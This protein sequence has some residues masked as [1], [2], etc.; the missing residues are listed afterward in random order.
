MFDDDGDLVVFPDR[1][2]EYAQHDGYH[3][4]VLMD[5]KDP[6]AQ[7]QGQW[8]IQELFGTGPDNWTG[9]AASLGSQISGNNQQLAS[10]IWW[11]GQPGD[12]GLFHNDPLQ[13]VVFPGLSQANKPQPK[14]SILPGEVKTISDMDV[15]QGTLVYKIST[16]AGAGLWA[17]DIPGQEFMMV[18]PG[19]GEGL[20]FCCPST[21]TPQQ[22]APNTQSKPRDL[23]LYAKQ[24]GNVVA[25]TGVSL[26]QLKGGQSM[27]GFRDANG[28]GIT[29]YA[30]KGGSSLT[31]QCNGSNGDTSGPS[32]FMDS[33]NNLIIF[34]A[35][36]AQGVFNGPKGQFET[37]KTD[38]QE[39]IKIPV[40]N[41]IAKDN[42]FLKQA[43]SYY[44]KACGG[45]NPSNTGADGS[46]A[47]GC[48]SCNN[49]PSS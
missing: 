43:A 15:R 23:S 28:S 41:T 32:I 3:V 21:G 2:E 39:K 24:D 49:T 42:Q 5:L 17:S 30:S 47:G 36:S 31:I 12:M 9:W 35:G 45:G 29:C 18:G 26:A 38:I 7:G 46:Q 22:E 11:P 8:E 34:T 13:P 44:C 33:K 27:S 37:T 10:G 14:N 4:A 40:E 25:G 20:F 16:P 6:M 48:P 19:T 1:P